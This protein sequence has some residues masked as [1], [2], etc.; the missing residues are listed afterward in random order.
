MK[1]IILKL[2]KFAE[3][4]SP[5]V[6]SAILIFC[7][8]FFASQC[9][10]QP[11]AHVSQF[12]QDAAERGITFTQRQVSIEV[13][14]LPDANGRIDNMPDGSLRIVI[15]TDFHNYYLF[16]SQLKRLIYYLMAHEI[17]GI[18]PGKGVMDAKLVYKPLRQSLIDDLFNKTIK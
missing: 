10:S 18:N 3:D 14:D 6:A 4:I 12:Y 15:D 11:S 9:K 7:I 2:T 16:N 1:N 8:S 5:W 17:L 13:K